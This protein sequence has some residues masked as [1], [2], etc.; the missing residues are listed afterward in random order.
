M[1]IYTLKKVTFTTVDK[2]E[3]ARK[4]ARNIVEKRLAACAQVIGP[5]TSTFWWKD[6]I[7]EV[8]EWL[9]ILKTR[10]DLYGKLEKAIKEIHPY[11]VPEILALPVVAGNQDYLDWLDNETGTS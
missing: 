4:I 10:N 9:L 3:D 7:D 5:I 8:E 2:E 6:K 1:G 11:E